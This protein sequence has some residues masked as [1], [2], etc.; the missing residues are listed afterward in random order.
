MQVPLD[1]VYIG[2]GVRMV[3]ALNILSTILTLDSILLIFFVMPEFNIGDGAD[4]SPEKT[5]SLTSML[6]SVRYR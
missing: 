2:E 3:I 4:A 1:I 5:S 6:A